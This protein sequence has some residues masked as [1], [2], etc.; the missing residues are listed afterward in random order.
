MAHGLD[1]LLEG[2]KENQEHL[3]AIDRRQSVEGRRWWWVPGRESRQ[4]RMQRLG[5][6]QVDKVNYFRG[7]FKKSNK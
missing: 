3:G 5:G 4:G 2:G 6:L 1:P 7:K